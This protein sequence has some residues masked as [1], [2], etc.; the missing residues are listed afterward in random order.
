MPKSTSRKGFWRKQG[1]GPQAGISQSG[2]LFP[3]AVAGHGPEDAPSENNHDRGFGS[4]R[5]SRRVPG[6]N[7]GGSSA[8][9]G[10]ASGTDVNGLHDQ[11]SWMP[12]ALGSPSPGQGPAPAGFARVLGSVEVPQI[13][14]GTAS[15]D[16]EPQV[17]GA[18]FRSTPFRPDMVV[19]GWSADR[20][21]V[22]GASL[23]GHF[24]RYNGAPRQDDFA[25][26]QLADGRLIVL[27]ADGVSQAEQSHLGA[28]TA[29]SAAAK[30]FRLPGNEDTF[31]LDWLALMEHV[32]WSLAVQAGSLFGLEEPD[33]SVAEHHLAT[34][35]VCA[36]VEP[37]GPE[38]LVAHIIGVG[39]SGAWILRGGEFFPIHGGKAAG[40]GGISSSAVLALPRRPTEL[41]P[42][43]V[44]IQCGDVLLLGTDGIG[45]P[46]GSGQ[47]GVGTLLRDLLE[48]PRPP[49]LIEFAHAMDFSRETFDDDRTLVAVF[50]RSAPPSAVPPSD[51]PPALAWSQEPEHHWLTP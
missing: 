23:R 8:Q 41:Q 39:D 30:W 42:F 11:S 16:V 28:S 34:T 22:R 27:V 51:G 10:G 14:I 49:S 2:H 26:H 43:V 12:P 33:L 4:R 45:D 20:V 1:D 9:G 24:H 25:I 36:V 19:D 13:V 32:A 50:P 38:M 40:E 17:I 15:P 3:P 44:E 35:L 31:Q 48:G 7:T 18:K 21:T 6:A 5:R 29:I 46:L 37:D 47:G